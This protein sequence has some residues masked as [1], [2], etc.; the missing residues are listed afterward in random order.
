MMNEI[1]I[2]ELTEAEEVNEDD[3]I[4]IIQNGVNKKVRAEKV[5]TGN[6]GG[7]TEEI[8][9]V[10]LWFSNTIP[11]NWL[12]LNGQAISRTEY[13]ELFEILGTTYGSGDDST[14]FNLPDMRQRV[15]VRIRCK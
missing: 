14:T 7:D 10:K 1:K 4:M 13:S 2:S 15:P 5:G 9:S 6:G 8:G 11:Q 3:L 12:L